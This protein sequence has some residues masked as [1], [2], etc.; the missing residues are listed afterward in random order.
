MYIHPHI[1]SFAFLILLGASLPTFVKQ[2]SSESQ[3]EGCVGRSELCLAGHRRGR[4]PLNVGS[5]TT[6]VANL[7][8]VLVMTVP[9]MGHFLPSD[10]GV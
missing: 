2:N 8:P 6:G 1:H 4:E 5:T 7:D 9:A 3:R 10:P